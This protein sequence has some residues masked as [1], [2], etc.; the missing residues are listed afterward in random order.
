M[1]F[2]KESLYAFMTKVK[3]KIKDL[4]KEATRWSLI[5]C[6]KHIQQK[7]KYAGCV[8]DLVCLWGLFESKFKNL[9]FKSVDDTKV[10]WWQKETIE[11]ILDYMW[12]VIIENILDYIFVKLFSLRYFTKQYISLINSNVFRC[13]ACWIIFSG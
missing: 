8:C 4:L 13:C 9:Y 12:K 5:P 1:T 3:N 7:K 6:I 10:G 2:E 11:N